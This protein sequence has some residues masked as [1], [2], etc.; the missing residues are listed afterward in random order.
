M[1][2]DVTSGV[3]EA[4]GTGARA[5]GSFIA[6]VPAAPSGLPPKV[7][8]PGAHWLHALPAPGGAHYVVGLVGGGDWS[9]R[10]EPR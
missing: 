6:F 9:L 3:L 2:A 7:E 10:V 5:W 4:S 8:L 1:A